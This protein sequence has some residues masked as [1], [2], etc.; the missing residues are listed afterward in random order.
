MGPQDLEVWQQCPAGHSHG[1]GLGTPREGFGLS[2]VLGHV[3]L[4]CS[5]TD[6]NGNPPMSAP[7]LQSDGQ[8]SCQGVRVWGPGPSLT[9]LAF[10]RPSLGLRSLLS[11]CEKGGQLFS[12][13]GNPGGAIWEGVLPA[14]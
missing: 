3:L 13:P 6:G 8:G 2:T 1:A 14:E 4:F 10:G 12:A 7:D 9:C 11:L 5:L